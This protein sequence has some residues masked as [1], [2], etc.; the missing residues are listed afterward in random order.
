MCGIVALFRKSRDVALEPLL[1]PMLDGQAHRGPDATGTWIDPDGQVALGHNRLAIVD[2]SP[3]GNQPM[4][5]ADGSL[6][7]TYNGEIYNWR[8]LRQG[9]EARGRH[10]RSQSD[11]EVILALYAEY[12]VDMLEQLR[13]MFA[14]A[15]WDS[16]KRQLFVARDRLGKKPV[17]LGES[18]AGLVV[19]SEIPTARRWPGLDL[20]VDPDALGLYLLRNLRHVPEPWTFWR[21]LR[22]LPPGHAMIAQDGRVVREWRY[23]H[24]RFDPRLVSAEEVRAM[25]DEAVALRRIA[26]VEVA[27]LLS[28]GVDSS[29][30]CQAMVAQGHAGLRTYALG[31]DEADEELARAQGMARR[32][33]T[34]H[35]SFVFDAKR[36]HAHH[37]ALIRRFGE[38]IALLPLAHAYELCRQIRNDGVKV[39]MTGHGAD[40]LFYGYTGHFRQA[41]LSDAL[42]WL[43]AALR[44][45]ARGVAPLLPA[46]VLHDGALVA[47]HAPGARKTALYADEAAAAPLAPVSADVVRPWLATWMDAP[48]DAYIDES[49]VI[50]LMHE[51]LHS[52][53]IAGDLPAMLASVECRCPF[54]DHK[55]VELA[56]ATPYRSKVSN[57]RLKAILKDALASRVP[58]ELLDAPKRGFGYHI[59]EAAVLAGPWKAEVDAA[60]AQLDDLGGLLDRR[61][62]AAIKQRFDARP[63][64]NT[65]QLVAKLYAIQIA[66]GEA[67]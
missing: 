3:L 38:P 40:E 39:V 22:R 65:A 2:L 54:L 45:V 35:R 6:Q 30:I 44:P 28:G 63:E 50:G 49:A 15:L 43:P 60:F 13:G 48:P 25:F 41:Q 32:L 8:E 55:L 61:A 20:A 18:A 62:V 67:G 19:A 46:G 1:G 57:G 16:R 51:N 5:S 42:A 29:G 58:A 27:A 66:L 17:I 24:P 4:A 47:G 37:T 52:V 56:W 12:G 9:L 23:W 64:P 14:F 34:R 21:G 36:F 31:R 59:Q 53:Q 33:G 26:D 7:I 10:F 11:T